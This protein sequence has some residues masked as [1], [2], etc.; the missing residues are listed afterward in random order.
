MFSSHNIPLIKKIIN[1]DLDE[2]DGLHQPGLGSEDTG[3]QDTSSRGD[4]LAATTVDGVSVQSNI[5]KIE[6]DAS[7]VLVTEN[8]LKSHK[9]LRLKPRKSL[10]S[11]LNYNEIKDTA[12]HSS[13]LFGGPLEASDTRVLDFVEILDSLGAVNE[14]VGASCLR[15]EAP[16]LPRLSDVIL[17]LLSQVAS[18]DLEVVPGVDL[19]VVNVLSQ[20]IR[21][22]DGP[23][24]QPEG[25]DVTMEL[26]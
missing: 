1:L 19:A 12:K 15:A 24:E 18:T 6:P 20:T 14:D 7:H 17:V 3:V 5:I 9:M 10:C 2:V 8:S 13:Y 26:W 22:G 11:G 21:H 25:R 4:D 16:D 23:H